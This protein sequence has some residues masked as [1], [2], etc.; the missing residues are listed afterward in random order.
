[1]ILSKGL[2]GYFLVG[3][4]TLFSVIACSEKGPP[5]ISIKWPQMLVE[6][7]NGAAF[8]VIFNKGKG[9][10]RLKSCTVKEYPQLNC[11][12]HDIVKGRMQLVKDFEVPA[13][14]TLELKPGGRH[15]MLFGLPENLK[16]EITIILHFEKTGDVPVKTGVVR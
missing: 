16:G 6:G 12:L 3:I 14:E 1:M 8:M 11:E 13:G 10:D 2:I 5:E 4:L 9:S 15:L 7:D